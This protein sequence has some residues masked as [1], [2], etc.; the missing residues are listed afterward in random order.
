MYM[1]I[2]QMVKH[3]YRRDEG[4][5]VFIIPFLQIGASFIVV[6]RPVFFFGIERIEM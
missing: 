3:G 2:I 6:P 1:A 5:S 4:R